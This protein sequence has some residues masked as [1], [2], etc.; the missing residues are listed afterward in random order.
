MG[1]R[2]VTESGRQHRRGTALQSWDGRAVNVA[3]LAVTLWAATLL[4]FALG[5]LPFL[6]GN[7]FAADPDH[8]LQLARHWCASCHLVES[9]G[10]ASDAAPTFAA[11]AHNPATTEQGLHG[12]L[13]KPHPPMPDL[14]LSRDQEDDV[15]AYIL[16][17][18]SD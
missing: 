6:I 16:S 10:I 13:A 7:A 4:A 18:K 8:G 11:I 5:T 12:W 14:K 17:L 9:G 3:P 1:R 15:L 2:Y